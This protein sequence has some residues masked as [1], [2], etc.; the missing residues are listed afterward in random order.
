MSTLNYQVNNELLMRFL[1]K[2]PGDE[3]VLE[4]EGRKYR[5]TLIEQVDEY[6][7]TSVRITGELLDG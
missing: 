5:F 1:D 2:E 7:E 4:H 3:I 6:D